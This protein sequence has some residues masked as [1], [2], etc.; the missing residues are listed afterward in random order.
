MSAPC[1]DHTVGMMIYGVDGIP[2]LR[3]LR[4]QFFFPHQSIF[5]ITGTTIR[6]RIGFLPPDALRRPK[7]R[8]EKTIYWV[9]K[10]D[11]LASSL[12]IQQKELY[13][14]KLFIDD[15]MQVI[16][17]P[18]LIRFTTFYPL[19]IFQWS[20]TIEIGLIGPPNTSDWP[21]SQR[22][23]QSGGTTVVEVIGKVSGSE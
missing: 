23:R 22:A 16:V 18:A 10:Y 9:C 7:R 11:G 1:D 13:H 8:N 12:V 5:I 15:C 19:N 3:R 17:I 20:I 2:L 21:I 6:H 4:I 14:S